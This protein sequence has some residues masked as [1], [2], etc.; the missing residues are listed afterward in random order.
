[1]VS[2]PQMA[3][4]KDEVLLE[5][6]RLLRSSKELVA[7]SREHIARSQALID[8]SFLLLASWPR[9]LASHSDAPAPLKILIVDDDRVNLSALGKFL[10][11][12]GFYTERAGDG[13]EAL[14]KLH[15]SRFDLVL[16]DIRMPQ[17]TG[18]ELA[19]EVRANFASTPIVLMTADLPDNPAELAAQVGAI[20]VVSKIPL[21]DLLE[22]IRQTGKKF[23]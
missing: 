23:H 4:Q 12:D 9:R 14:E 18:L 20:H 1:M 17:M 19:R 21:D 10:E 7:T 11:L 16:S 2:L 5:S 15:R 22:K 6:R 13:V 8:R 3:R